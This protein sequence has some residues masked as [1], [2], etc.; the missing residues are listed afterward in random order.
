MGLIVKWGGGGIFN[1]PITKRLPR[2]F[3]TRPLGGGLRY[4]GVRM[5]HRGD[6]MI[7]VFFCCGRKYR[8][9]DLTDKIKSKKTAATTFIATAAKNIYVQHLPPRG[10]ISF[11]SNAIVGD[12]RVVHQL[13][14]GEIANARRCAGFDLPHLRLLVVGRGVF[15]AIVN[16]ED[17]DAIVSR[18]GSGKC[19]RLRIGH[20]GV[21]DR[22]ESD[23]VD[24]RRVHRNELH[25]INA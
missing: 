12:L 20:V 11:K 14:E 24:A 3:F 10:G 17:V 15:C 6:Q 5:G 18:Y 16:L 23:A 2:R 22:F 4:V 13:L 25:G 19:V 9:G 1:N 7:V 8:R 21:E